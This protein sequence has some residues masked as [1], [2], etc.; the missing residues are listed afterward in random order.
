[1]SENLTVTAFAQELYYYNVV[2][3][4]DQ[5]NLVIWNKESDLFISLMR[6]ILPVRWFCGTSKSLRINL[7]YMC[8]LF[9]LHLC[10]FVPFE[11]PLTNFKNGQMAA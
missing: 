11:S 3:L 9:F 10:L 1:M 4:Q 7:Q 8:T 5:E 6:P 2:V